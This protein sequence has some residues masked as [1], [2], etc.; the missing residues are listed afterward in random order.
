[1]QKVRDLGRLNPKLDIPIDPSP[2]SSG[3]PAEEEVERF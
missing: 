2:K 3:N 1:M